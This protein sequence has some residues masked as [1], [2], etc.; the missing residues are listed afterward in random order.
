MSDH[1]YALIDD[2]GRRVRTDVD[3]EQIAAW[4]RR[5]AEEK[6]EREEG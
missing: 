1:D 3:E 5:S 2:H 4:L 6:R